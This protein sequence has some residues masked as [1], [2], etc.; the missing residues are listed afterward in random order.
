[1]MYYFTHPSSINQKVHFYDLTQPIHRL[2]AAP[3][4]VTAIRTSLMWMLW[5]ESRDVCT[6]SPIPLYLF[7]PTISLFL[8]SSLQLCPLAG[9]IDPT[10]SLQP[11][12]SFTGWSTSCTV[13]V[14][15]I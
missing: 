2:T 11:F 10:L 14:G 7:S 3:A 12:D 13:E 4:D 9:S 1:M 8:G 15:L 5:L 6:F